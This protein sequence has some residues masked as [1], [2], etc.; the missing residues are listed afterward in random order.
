M[1]ELIFFS[2]F[3]VFFFRYARRDKDTKENV[4]KELKIFAHMMTLFLLSE[5]RFKEEKR[6]SKS[7][8]CLYLNLSPPPNVFDDSFFIY[9]C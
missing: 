3:D 9:F 7:V 1:K 5:Q 8:C 2:P 6:K 4:E